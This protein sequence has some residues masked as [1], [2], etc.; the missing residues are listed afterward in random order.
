MIHNDTKKKLVISESIDPPELSEIYHSSQLEKRFGG[1]VDTP[2]QF[3]PPYVGSEFFP[4]NDSSHIG[5][6]KRENYETVITE[7]PNLE[8]HPDFLAE[9][10]NSRDFK[11]LMPIII[12]P[13]I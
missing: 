2:Q 3:W 10:Q 12:E 13:E 4:N 9:G 6:I 5:F 8:C 11:R 7:N 1:D